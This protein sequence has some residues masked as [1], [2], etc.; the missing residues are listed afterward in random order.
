DRM[1]LL[2]DVKTG[3]VLLDHLGD[4]AQMPLGAFQALQDLRM[5]LMKVHA[6][7]P[8]PIPLDRM[9]QMIDDRRQPTTS[10]VDFMFLN[11]IG[12]S[13]PRTSR[14]SNARATLPKP[15]ASARSSSL[16][17]MWMV[18]TASNLPRISYCCT[19]WGKLTGHN[20][21]APRG[22][23]AGSGAYS[24]TARLPA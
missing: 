12:K 16:P 3:A 23:T 24:P 14:C 2:G 10:V 5:T 15:A 19:G 6:R 4:A 13:R 21:A 7:L 22:S 18:W 20:C 11:A 1:Q 9:R 8:H 17:I